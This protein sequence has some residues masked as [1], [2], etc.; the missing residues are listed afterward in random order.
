M[1]SAT[2][3]AHGEDN[4]KKYAWY[5]ILL[6]FGFI[7]IGYL[8]GETVEPFWRT[9]CIRNVFGR[10]VCYPPGVYPW[11]PYGYYPLRHTR[12]MSYDLRGDPWYIPKNY[13][14]WNNSDVTPYW[15]L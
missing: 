13:Y 12:L 15:Y 2:T 6:L 9:N 5:L 10:K 4:T 14:A 11:Y 3:I 1:D 8:F 7:V